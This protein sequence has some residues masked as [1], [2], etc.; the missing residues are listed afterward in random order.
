MNRV[1]VLSVALAIPSIGLADAKKDR[2]T[3]AKADRIFAE[4]RKLAKDG[5]WDEACPKFEE[6]YRLDPAVGTQINLATCYDK[7]GDLE[8]AVETFRTARLALEPGKDDKRIAYVDEQIADLEARIATAAPPTPE[9]APPPVEPAP[10]ASAPESSVTANAAL[11]TSTPDD[12]S[13]L[14]YR[15]YAGIG[16]AAVGGVGLVGG[17]LYGSN[18]SRKLNEAKTLCGEELVCA[19]ATFAQGQSLIAEARSSATWSTA[20]FVGGGVAIAGGV[21]LYLMSQDE[22]RS[23]AISPTVTN[24]S[25]GVSAFGTF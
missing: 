5:K 16:L 9:T 13:S 12:G 1:L 8:A 18:A 10:E 21:A 17:I 15:R 2:A 20:L 22:E 25:V 11:T 14:R 7:I 23:T 24:D 19:D 6:S 3:R 4:G